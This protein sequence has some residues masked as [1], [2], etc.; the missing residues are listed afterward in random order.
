[1]ARRNYRQKRMS[2]FNQFDI[3]RILRE[4]IYELEQENDRIEKMVMEM[5]SQ[6][7]P[8]RIVLTWLRQMENNAAEIIYDNALI[9]HDI[10]GFDY[11]RATIFRERG[12]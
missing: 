1:M 10:D 4:N 9:Q 6:N 8:V 11:A 2:E 12:R 5:L 3:E 7:I